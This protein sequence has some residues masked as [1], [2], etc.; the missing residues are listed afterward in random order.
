MEKPLDLFVEGG[1]GLADRFYGVIRQ[2]GAEI[3]QMHAGRIGRLHRAECRGRF[4]RQKVAH[5]LPKSRQTIGAYFDKLR[6]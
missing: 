1:D 5:Q 6:Q 2:G 3:A 4:A